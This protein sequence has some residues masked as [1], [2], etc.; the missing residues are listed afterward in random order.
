LP[1]FQVI[2]GFGIK[3]FG[4]NNR[5]LPFQVDQMAFDC[6]ADHPHKDLP[7]DYFTG[8]TQNLQVLSQLFRICH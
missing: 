6:S 1:E 5:F 8:T 7:M 3:A 4:T 2:Y